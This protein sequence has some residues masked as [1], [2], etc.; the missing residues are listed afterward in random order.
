M[1][2]SIP[3]RLVTAQPIE[4]LIKNILF[5]V[6]TVS[7]SPVLFT[8]YQ[9]SPAS[10]V[11]TI[12]AGYPPANPV[13]AFVKVRLFNDAVNTLDGKLGRT[14]QFNPAFVVL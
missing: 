9:L 7:V 6:P 5:M 11:F 3:P 10:V 12:L 13:A 14:N 4:E 1:V 8:T 2:F